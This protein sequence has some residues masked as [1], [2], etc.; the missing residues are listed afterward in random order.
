MRNSRNHSA[1]RVRSWYVLAVTPSRPRSRLRG[2]IVTLLT[3]HPFISRTS[4]TSF[5][6]P[7]PALFNPYRAAPVPRFALLLTSHI[8][9]QTQSLTT[10]RSPTT[11]F[12]PFSSGL[13][14]SLLP[15]CTGTHNQVDCSPLQLFILLSLLPTLHTRSP[16]AI[17]YLLPKLLSMQPAKPPFNAPNAY[18]ALGKRFR[19][20]SSPLQPLSVYNFFSFSTPFAFGM[21]LASSSFVTAWK[22]SSFAL[23]FNESMLLLQKS[24]ALVLRALCLLRIIRFY[25]MV[26]PNQLSTLRP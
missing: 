20:D 25:I 24:S 23:S 4:S 18:F 13:L 22:T 11:P 21:A 1:Q 26:L 5:A 2:I 7:C 15:K 16:S 14:R 3:P 6:L 8:K 19:Q 9:T 12:R 10:T 17:K